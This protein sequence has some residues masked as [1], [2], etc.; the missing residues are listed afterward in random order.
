M[1]IRDSFGWVLFGIVWGVCI[2][3]I[4]LNS[5]SVERFKKISMV[6]YIIA[7]WA[8]VLAIVP[9]IDVYK[10]QDQYRQTHMIG[11]VQKTF[12]P[13]SGKTGAVHAADG[14]NGKPH[15]EEEN[16]QKRDNEAR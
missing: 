11:G 13:G 8:I 15:S 14:K 4:V 6:F 3:G 5:I 16:H 1:C 9:M 12:Q 7:G 10:R 2:L